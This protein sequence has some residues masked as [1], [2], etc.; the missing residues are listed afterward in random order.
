MIERD[1]EKTIIDAFK[2][3]LNEENI[4]YI[5]AWQPDNI[6]G[7]ENSND[8]S[9]ITVKVQPRNYDSPT[10]PTA[11]FTVSLTLTTRAEIDITGDNYLKLAERIA[12]KL[13]Q[14]QDSLQQCINDLSTNNCH[15]TGF[16]LSG[17]DVITDKENCVF[18]YTHQFIVYG[19]CR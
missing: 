8:E 7:F 15:V 12:D 6:K 19:V 18:Q 10:I 2:D 11:Q 5:G 4:Q 9:Y 17:G 1:L 14:W 3:S 16:Q 13:S